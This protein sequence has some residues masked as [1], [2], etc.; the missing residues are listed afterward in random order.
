[1]IADEIL[2]VYRTNSP[3]LDLSGW[4]LF[5]SL[6]DLSLLKITELTIGSYCLRKLPPLSD[7]LR[8]LNL[9]YT[10]SMLLTLPF[11]RSSSLKINGDEQL[12]AALRLAKTSINPKKYTMKQ[13]CMKFP[14][15]FDG[16]RCVLSN[17]VYSAQDSRREV[18]CIRAE[19][20]ATKFSFYICGT[21]ALAN[22]IMEK[23]CTG[24]P[25]VHPVTGQPLDLINDIIHLK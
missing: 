20:A 23:T 21:E 4:E 7:K 2:K 8:V 24:Q 10:G 9:P 13:L 6:P 12:L 3:L 1:M 19:A 15:A 14:G 17:E 22:Y 18:V 5:T 16:I 25:L 11:K